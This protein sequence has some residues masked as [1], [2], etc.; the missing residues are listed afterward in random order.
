MQ[1]LEINGN[2]E[3]VSDT[4]DDVLYLTEKYMGAEAKNYI[5][6]MISTLLALIDSLKKENSELMDEISELA[7]ELEEATS[8]T[9]D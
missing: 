4:L 1:R 7:E 6:G 2:C 8:E 3:N 5:N 9:E